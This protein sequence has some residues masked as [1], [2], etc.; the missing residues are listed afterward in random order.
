MWLVCRVDFNSRDRGGIF[1]C[2]AVPWIPAIG[3]SSNSYLMTQ[4]PWEGWLRLL[5]ITGVVFIVYVVTVARSV[6]GRRGTNKQEDEQT[7]LLDSSS[8]SRTP[9]R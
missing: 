7:S 3:L 9:F 5:I 1:L 8:S 6:G 2:P 4:R